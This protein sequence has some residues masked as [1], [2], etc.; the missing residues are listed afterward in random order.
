M[1]KLLFNRKIQIWLKVQPNIS[2]LTSPKAQTFDKTGRFLKLDAN[3]MRKIINF[4]TPDQSMYPCAKMFMLEP[5]EI[6]KL[7]ISDYSYL[8]NI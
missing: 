5:R 8:N 2:K 1:F 4:P 6:A 7:Q 3:H